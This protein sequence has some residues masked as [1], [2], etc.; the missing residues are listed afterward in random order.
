MGFRRN[1]RRVIGLTLPFLPRDPR[2]SFPARTEAQG[3][4]RYSLPRSMLSNFLYNLP[5]N[6]HFFDFRFTPRKRLRKNPVLFHV[7]T[8]SRAHRKGRPKLK[9]GPDVLHSIVIE[10]MGLACH[11]TTSLICIY[12]SNLSPHET[13]RPKIRP[14]PIWLIFG[15]SI[16]LAQR[17][18]MMQKLASSDNPVQ[19]Y[20]LSKIWARKMPKIRPSPIWLIFGQSIALAQRSRMMQKLASSDNPVQSYDLSKIWARKMPK[21]RSS[22][23][24]LIFGQ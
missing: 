18:R 1:P 22:P 15:Q 20:D 24:W 11:V 5:L 9:L 19:S 12:V 6:I 23:I 16:A 14:S 4:L 13:I 7:A 21:I 17:S 3:L 2:I 10:V 8:L